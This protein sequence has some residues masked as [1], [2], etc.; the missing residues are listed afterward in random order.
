MAQASKGAF[1]CARVVALWAVLLVLLVGDGLG[2]DAVGLEPEV[3][4]RVMTF[5]YP[6]YGI[7]DG[8]GGAG[9]MVHWRQ[10]DPAKRDI[11]ASTHYPTLGA[12]DSHDAKL[13]EQHCK[14]AV[15]A[16]IDTFIV[17]WWGHGSYSD[18]AMKVILDGCHRHKLKVCIYYETVPR[19]Q[20][21]ESAAKDIL[22]VLEKY[23]RHKAYLKVA[24][25]PVVFVYGRTLREIGLDEWARAAKLLDE[26]YR[27]G[28]ALIGDRFKADAAAVFDGLHTYNIAGALRDKGLAEV[29]EWVS[30]TYPSWVKLAERAGK[31]S[32]VTVIPGY[33][34][35]KIRKP[36]LVVRRFGGELYRVQWQ[37]AIAAK[38]RWIL[39]TSF[40]EWHEGSEIEP[41]FEHGKLYLELTAEFAG[42]F[43]AGSR[44][45]P[46]RPE[47]SADETGLRK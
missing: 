11:A 1:L 29:R 47:L 17:S 24:G 32:T 35:T 13:I 12:Y 40:N 20:T 15:G 45:V 25:Q 8:P 6:W 10:V 2:I 31:I 21:A 26:R 22:K 3:P 4:R 36:G 37:A 42:R 41:S 33:D 38:P 28:V 14:W 16:G 7:P 19:P 34:D 39:I 43:K 46:R 30:R 9:R 23:A 27:G 18:R 44:A 5:Y